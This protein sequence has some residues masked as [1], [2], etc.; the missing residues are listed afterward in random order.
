MNSSNLY[1]SPD[2][3]SVEVLGRTGL[4]YRESGRVAFVDSEVLMGASGMVIYRDSIKNW[5]SSANDTITVDERDR[6]VENIRK[7]FRTQGYEID[8]F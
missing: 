7:L 2:G 6:I 8:V 5:D 4:C 3:Y 1:E